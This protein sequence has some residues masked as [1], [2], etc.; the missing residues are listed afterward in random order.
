MTGKRDLSRRTDRLE[1]RN[2]PEPLDV[3]I[4]GDPDVDPADRDPDMVI[5]DGERVK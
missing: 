5:V 3:H 4:G 2:P 1:D